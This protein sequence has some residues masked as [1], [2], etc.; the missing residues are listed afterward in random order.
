MDHCLRHWRALRRGARMINRTG[1]AAEN[2]RVGGAGE[3]KAGLAGDKLG[4]SLLADGKISRAQLDEALSI[5]RQDQRQDQRQLG[6]I[7]ISAGFVTPADLA[8]ALAKWLRLE[9]V[10]LTEKDVDRS[11][12]VVAEAKLLRRHN[13]LPLRVEEGRLVVAMSDPANFYAIED[14][15]MLSGYPIRPVV[16]VEEEIQRV[17]NRV[18][19]LGGDVTRMLADAAGDGPDGDHGVVEL[20]EHINAENA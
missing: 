3:K 8:M 15:R 20:G 6:Q 13:M 1:R 17:F 11:V 2:T 10:E 4:E 14:L 9:Y 19:A 18:Y 7:L 5:Q 12:T 16:L